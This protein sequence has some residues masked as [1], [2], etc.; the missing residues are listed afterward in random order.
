[1]ED[2][3]CTFDKMDATH[4]NN[5]NSWY[6]CLE[7]DYSCLLV[8]LSFQKQSSN[9]QYF[10]GKIMMVEALYQSMFSSFLH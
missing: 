1:M 2:T 5:N 4:N 7:L 6:G 8:A 3:T 10:T 9:T